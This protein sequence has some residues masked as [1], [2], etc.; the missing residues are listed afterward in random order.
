M[1]RFWELDQLDEIE[2]DLMSR[3]VESDIAQASQRQLK[4]PEE[5]PEK[6]KFICYVVEYGLCVLPGRHETLKKARESIDKIRKAVK[7]NDEFKVYEIVN[8]IGDDNRSRTT[9]R[10][11]PPTKWK[12]Y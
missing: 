10:L 7:T 6:E 4:K 9:Q 5:E 11:V 8:V 3:E 12:H 2:L 1:P